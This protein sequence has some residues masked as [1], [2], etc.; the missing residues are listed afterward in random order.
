VRTSYG[1]SNDTNYIYLLKGSGTFEFYRYN[2][3]ADRWETMSPAPF[4]ASGKPYKTGS[5]IAYDGGDTIWTLKGNYNE[6]FAYSIAGNNWTSKAGMPMGYPRKR[7]K[8]GAALASVGRYVYAL[9]GGNTDQ[10][11]S[12]SSNE[13]VWLTS[14]PLPA[15]AKRVKN[16]GSLVYNPDLEVLYAFR[17]NNTREFWSY[18]LAS[19]LDGENGGRN[20]PMSDAQLRD[21]K[22][23]MRTAPN[24]FVSRATVSYTLPRSG[25]VSL[26]LYDV[27]GKLVRS[28]VD[29]YAPAGQ[30]TAQLDAARLATGIYL[31]KFESEGFRATRKLVLDR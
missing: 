3:D 30:H 9:K 15:L 19:G 2:V 10:F 22:Y 16:G 12:Y 27:T 23:G 24:P 18:G 26:R 5:A 31:L 28:L 11:L 1:G 14:S 17:G 4:G 13:Q 7:A 20:G 29:G 6:F 8:D 25:Q 21:L